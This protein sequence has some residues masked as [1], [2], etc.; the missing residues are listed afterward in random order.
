MEGKKSD[1]SPLHQDL[2]SKVTL[3]LSVGCERREGSEADQ[4]R[5]EEKR[6]EPKRERAM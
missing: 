4:R 1:L 3:L 6:S 5:R 2:L